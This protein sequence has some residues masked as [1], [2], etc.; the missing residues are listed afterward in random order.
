M[1]SHPYHVSLTEIE[2]NDDS[3]SFEVALCVW[4]ADLEKALSLQAG[5][6]V[7]L[8]DDP[9]LDQLL[10]D[11]I[12]LCFEVEQYPI[13]VEDAQPAIDLEQTRIVEALRVA[14]PEA[15]E[16]LKLGMALGGGKEK[17][18]GNIV[19]AGHEISDKEA[20]LYFEVTGP[21]NPELC[22]IE[23]RVMFELNA[24]QMNH[25]N[26]TGSRMISTVVCS[27]TEKRRP[28]TEGATRG[29]VD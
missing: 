15:A 10:N 14:I 7:N 20:W 4:P 27:A 23:N 18:R 25:I 16:V 12:E 5:R 19:W 29:I 28:L 8:D 24:D 11:Y 22:V 9:E 26:F 2:W 6:P 3:G 17:I 21:D 1:A 13:D